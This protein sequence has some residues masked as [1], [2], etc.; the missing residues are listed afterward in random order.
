MGIVM[1]YE[2]LGTKYP[3]DTIDLLFTKVMN[4]CV[5]AGDTVDLAYCRFGPKCSL[6]LNDFYGKLNIINSEL[7][8]WDI[9]LQNNA[10][11]MTTVYE[12]YEPLK[13]FITSD[14]PALINWIKSLP[15]GKYKPVIDLTNIKHRAV[16]TILIMARPDIELDI[17]NTS[18]DIFTFVRDA[19]V[20]GAKPHDSY[21]IL[22]APDIELLTAQGDM[23][24]DAVGATYSKDTLL[25][26]YTVLPA[27]FGN[28]QII[29]FT[30]PIDSEWEPVLLKCINTLK[31][32]TKN[33]RK[34]KG[35]TVRDFVTVR[36]EIKR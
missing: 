3:I 18:S 28:S 35:K 20:N 26:D 7:P 8:E 36:R 13:L 12:E 10:L 17:R 32:H 15:A 30:S 5:E 11:A 23:F 29:T 22:R 24:V 4:E 2:K 33:T 6:I 21:W 16:L 9:I 31:E 34:I 1:L 14:F 19:W 27:E 25:R